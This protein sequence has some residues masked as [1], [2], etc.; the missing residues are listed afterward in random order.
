MEKLVAAAHLKTSFILG[1]G[2]MTLDELLAG[3][4]FDF[5]AERGC[6]SLERF[7]FSEKNSA[8]PMVEYLE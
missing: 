2:K 5:F 4:L 8:E 3:I 7:L 6:C 1:V